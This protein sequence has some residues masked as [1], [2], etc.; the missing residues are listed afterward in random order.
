MSK[1]PI[2]FQTGY[3]IS[4]VKYYGSHTYMYRYI[5]PFNTMRHGEGSIMSY[6]WHLSCFSD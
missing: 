3:E 5:S 4:V 1:T 6:S 2:L